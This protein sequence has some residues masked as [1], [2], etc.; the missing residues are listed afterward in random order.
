MMLDS[1]KYIAKLFFFTKINKKM[2]H[3]K[4]TMAVIECLSRFAS[5]AELYCIIYYFK[6]ENN[7]K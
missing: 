5:I 1:M 4:N 2:S 6:I 3:K 7:D